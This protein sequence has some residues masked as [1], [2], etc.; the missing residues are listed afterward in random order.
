MMKKI[1]LILLF[2]LPAF[3]I[4]TFLDFCNRGNLSGPLAETVGFL[5]LIG[6]GPSVETNAVPFMKV[7]QMDGSFLKEVRTLRR[8]NSSKRWEF[9]EVEVTYDGKKPQLRRELYKLDSRYYSGQDVGRFRNSLAMEG[10]NKRNCAEAFNRLKDAQGLQLNTDMLLINGGKKWVYTVP[11]LE[12]LVGLENLEYLVIVPPA[13]KNFG[14]SEISDLGP[15]ST[16]KNLM[17]LDLRSSRVRDMGP[18]IG[19]YKLEYLDLGDNGIGRIPNLAKMVGLRKLELGHNQL[20]DASFVTGMENLR[21]LNLAFNRLV[22]IKG[23]ETL[24]N[25]NAL[26]I[27]ENPQL[28]DI[29]PAKELWALTYLSIKKTSAKWSGGKSPFVNVSQ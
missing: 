11:T 9:N 4:D 5:K 10:N 24:K 2:S 17:W 13:N 8:R 15:L 21:L 23:V 7:T 27:S 18:L 29:N 25:L 20:L 19:L 16:L 14:V 12:P 3:S 22:N 26:I 28:Y 6:Q 1:I